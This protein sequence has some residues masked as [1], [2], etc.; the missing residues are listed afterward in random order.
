MIAW[1]AGRI[2]VRES[3]A[4]HVW[5]KRRPTVGRTTGSETRA[6]LLRTG[7][8]GGK[9]RPTVGE[10][11]ATLRVPETRAELRRTGTARARG[12][13][14]SGGRRRPSGCPRLAPNCGWGRRGQRPAPNFYARARRGARGDLRSGGRRRAFGCARA[15]R[16]LRASGAFAGRGLCCTASG[17][18]AAF[19]AGETAAP[20]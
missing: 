10:T 8:A 9:R 17:A 12:D 20:T 19:Q 16:N 5:V 4:E 1:L 2:W 6:E 11:V 14:R 13:L 18:G 15:A 7:T 3:R